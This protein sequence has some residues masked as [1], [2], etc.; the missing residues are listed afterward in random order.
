M[1][2]AMNRSFFSVIFGG[3]GTTSGASPA[4]GAQEQGERHGGVSAST[5]ST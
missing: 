2:A 5:G 1:C 3:F 4:A